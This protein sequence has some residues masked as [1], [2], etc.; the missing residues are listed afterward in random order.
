LLLSRVG[1]WFC[2]ERVPIT[3]SAESISSSSEEAR[4]EKEPGGIVDSSSPSLSPLS[5]GEEESWAGGT[6]PDSSS[7]I[8]VEEDEG[9]DPDCVVECEE[10]EWEGEEASEGPLEVDSDER[11][12]APGR[13]LDEIEAMDSV[14]VDGS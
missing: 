1:T 11:V 13:S 14:G 10:C 9:T 8:S 5:S 12:C 7:E 4:D 6:A 3:V 2:A